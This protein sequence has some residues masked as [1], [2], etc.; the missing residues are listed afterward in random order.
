MILL[1]KKSR[2]LALQTKP[3]F[4]ILQILTGFLLVLPVFL[5]TSCNYANESSFIDFN[6]IS[7]TSVYDGDSFKD[8][9]E[10]RYRLLGINAAEIPKTQDMPELQKFF[11]FAAKNFLSQKILNKVIQCQYYKKDYY[12]RYLVIPSYQEQDLAVAMLEQGLVRMQYISNNPNDYYYYPDKNYYKKLIVAQN[13]AI[14]KKV[15]IWNYSKADQEIIF[16]K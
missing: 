6:K 5:F 8:N 15:G 7:V 3:K 12:G 10:N 2:N 4:K 11:A 9:K 14:N 13:R 16:A 1:L